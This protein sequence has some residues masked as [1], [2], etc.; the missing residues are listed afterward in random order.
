MHSARLTLKLTGVIMPD[1]PDEQPRRGYIYPDPG[2]RV[3]LYIE[4]V[5]LAGIDSLA[6]A[7]QRSR[8]WMANRLLKLQ[9]GQPDEEMI[10]K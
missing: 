5:V 4:P 2:E 9:L 10:P 7:H 3:S 6:Q 8:S 1:K